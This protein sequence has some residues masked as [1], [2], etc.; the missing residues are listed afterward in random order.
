MQTTKTDED[1]ILRALYQIATHSEKL[2]IKGSML[3]P[4]YRVRE[5]NSINSFTEIKYIDFKT[6]VILN[7]NYKKYIDHEEHCIFP[8]STHYEE[9]TKTLIVT[10]YR[11]PDDV[12]A[13]IKHVLIGLPS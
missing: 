1:N 12:V 8:F 3:I 2:N 13:R 10:S 4:I 7:G 9:N 11:A 5:L 6:L